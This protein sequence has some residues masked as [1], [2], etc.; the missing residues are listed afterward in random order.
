MFFDIREPAIG[1]ISN[2]CAVRPIAA[3]VCEP[4]ERGVMGVYYLRSQK[5]SIV[6]PTHC[7][8]TTILHPRW[9][10]IVLY[11]P[12]TQKLMAQLTAKHGRWQEANHI[13][14]D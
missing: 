4:L 5:I 14:T 2:S 10:W 13:L 3:A 7:G 11:Y 1:S 9:V 6:T 8:I 12:A